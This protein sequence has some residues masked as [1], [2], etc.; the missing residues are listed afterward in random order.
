MYVEHLMDF[1]APPLPCETE[2]APV[3]LK[4]M[5][6]RVFGGMGHCFMFIKIIISMSNTVEYPDRAQ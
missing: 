1:Q 5:F 2:V 6:Q 4:L 3:S